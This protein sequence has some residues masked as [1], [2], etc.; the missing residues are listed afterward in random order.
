MTIEEI[1]EKKS[2]IVYLNNKKHKF[3]LELPSLNDCEYDNKIVLHNRYKNYINH[4]FV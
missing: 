1:T 3:L 4:K 2:Q